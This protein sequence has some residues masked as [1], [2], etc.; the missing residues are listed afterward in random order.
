[1]GGWEEDLAGF[2]NEH[3]ASF[4]HYFHPPKAQPVFLELQS[5]ENISP[6]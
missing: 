4:P 3:I 2:S 1:M 6:V 5:F